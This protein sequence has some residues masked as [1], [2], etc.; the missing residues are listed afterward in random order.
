MLEAR[1]KGV[2]S[3]QLTLVVVRGA[4]Q[5]LFICQAKQYTECKDD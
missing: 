2:G 3:C 4:L 1:S 5:N